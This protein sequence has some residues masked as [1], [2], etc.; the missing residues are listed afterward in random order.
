MLVQVRVPARGRVPTRGQ[1]QCP[2]Q[3]PA[4]AQV[5]WRAL[6]LGMVRAQQ[7]GAG[8][9]AAVRA[10]R[11]QGQAPPLELGPRPVLGA[12]GFASGWAWL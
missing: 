1:W 2:A 12:R 9:R 7:A 3:L 8:G 4:E 11:A 10:F 6:V 5:R